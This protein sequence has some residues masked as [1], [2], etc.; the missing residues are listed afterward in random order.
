MKKTSIA[1][2]ILI[3]LNVTM[4][5]ATSGKAII[6]NYRTYWASSSSIWYSKFFLTNITNESI[7]VK[8]K[9]YNKDGVLL[10]DVGNCIS[11]LAYVQ[12][13]FAS[14]YSSC[15][16]SSD[17]TISMTIVPHRTIH[18]NLVPSSANDDAGY[19]FVEWSQASQ[20]NNGLVMVGVI[21]N[22]S[23]SSPI[24]INNGLPF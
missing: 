3:F 16:K 14:S 20:V 5:F 11:G 10:T 21:T 19:G 22:N 4:A 1:L 9:L 17:S 13:E 18:F 8:I 23:Y 6:P 12:P 24:P 2:L 15:S 7:D